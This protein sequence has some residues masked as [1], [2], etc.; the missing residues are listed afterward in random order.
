MLL[1]ISLQ[2]I[3]AF[4]QF[5]SAFIRE[6]MRVPLKKIREKRI[7]GENSHGSKAPSINSD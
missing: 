4:S 7:K 6:I 3:M 5:L 2:N 1:G